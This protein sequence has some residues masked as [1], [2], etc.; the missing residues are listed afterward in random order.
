M[1]LTEGGLWPVASSFCQFSPA[2]CALKNMATN[3]ML[4]SIKAHPVMSIIL[5][6]SCTCEQLLFSVYYFGLTFAEY[7]RTEVKS[8]V[9]NLMSGVFRCCDVI[10]ICWHVS[11]DVVSVHGELASGLSFRVVVMLLLLRRRVVAVCLAMMCLDLRPNLTPLSRLLA[12]I[13]TRCTAVHVLTCTLHVSMSSMIQTYAASAMWLCVWSAVLFI[14][15]LYSVKQCFCMI[16][17]ACSV[18]KRYCMESLAFCVCHYCFS[19]SVL[20]WLV[21]CAS[22]LLLCC[23]WHEQDE[24]LMRTKHT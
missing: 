17:I 22:A 1:L 10:V 24:Y 20:L 19:S 15:S 9:V 3:N 7:I 4:H 14:C 12:S 18:V 11:V 23:I 16:F 13:V 5:L 2:S 6:F 8:F 21:N